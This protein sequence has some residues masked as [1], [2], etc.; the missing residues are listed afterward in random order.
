MIKKHYTVLSNLLAI[1]MLMPISSLAYD[2]DWMILN[3]CSGKNRSC[4][5]QGY[6]QPEIKPDTD[7]G[8]DITLN[9]DSGDML[10]NKMAVLTG[11]AV[12]EQQ[13]RRLVADKIKIFFKD[14]GGELDKLEAF[15]NVRMVSPQERFNGSYAI[16]DVT[17]QE[18]ELHNS[19]YY[20]FS[21]HSFGSSPKIVIDKNDVIHL[22]KA[23]YST[24]SPRD[25][26][27]HLKAKKL[28][29][30]QHSGWGNA[31]HSI[32]YIKDKPVFYWP[33]V[34]FPIDD[35]RKSGLLL[36][37]MQS[38]SYLGSGFGIPYYWNIA[39]N[40]DAT[41]TPTWNTHSG[42]RVFNQFRYLSNTYE[43][44]LEL[45]WFVN[46]RA[47]K[48]FRAEKIAQPGS[49]AVNSV[50]MQRLK[51]LSMRY[52]LN[53]QH[54]GRPNDSLLYQIYYV[55]VGDDNFISNTG[56]RILHRDLSRD[57]H[58]L[59]EI[60]NPQY[61]PQNFLLNYNSSFGATDVELRQYQT[62]YAFNAP[63]PG[64]L[65]RVLPS[66]S[67]TF[68]THNYG[69]FYSTS[70]GSWFNFAQDKISGVS[71]LTTGNRYHVETTLSRP[72]DYDPGWFMSPSVKL[73]ILSEELRRPSSEYNMAKNPSRI[74]P[75]Y[76]LD[77]GLIFERE[78]VVPSN[79]WTQT[80]EPRIKYLYTPHKNQSLLPVFESGVKKFSYGELYQDN[81]FS[82]FDRISSTNQVSVGLSSNFMNSI[83]EELAGI[84]V[85]QIYYL[86]RLRQD[87]LESTM[88]STRHTPFASRA[89]Y[90]INMHWQV[91]AD[92]VY[93]YK[94][95]LNRSIVVG[96]SYIPTEYNIIN[97]NY[98]YSND[99]SGVKTN[100]IGISF[101][102]FPR[103][104]L[105]VQGITHYDIVQRNLNKVGVGLEFYKCCYS[106]KLTWLHERTI[107]NI[108]N[109]GARSRKY[110]NTVG[111]QF[112][113]TGFT[114]VSAKRPID[115]SIPGAVL[116]SD[117]QNN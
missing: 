74:L 18:K 91:D 49:I 22:E 51:P 20:L 108:E 98:D 46:E 26:I 87:P 88:S 72:I 35:R 64:N 69:G 71:P 111:L 45:D 61:L 39:P 116:P 23:T 56:Q 24:C 36:P 93:D 1:A 80:L 34:S 94:K 44:T 84:G 33:Y 77:S 10:M 52:G 67:Q 50:Q 110:N 99:L 109:T 66:L 54:V 60:F 70:K 100:Q 97:I 37:I 59:P 11:G 48:G 17:K 15:G 6:Y 102:L 28:E 95:R 25:R 114:S 106:I 32:L 27:W 5:C 62:L 7:F 3:T 58:T 113:L 30:D 105:L 90:K 73:D 53:L 21:S 19:T 75:T 78:L 42:L 4:L 38:E 104:N 68:L 8:R 31:W 89:F 55:K 101:S 82:G 92:W 43:G 81:R 85:G 13:Q 76:S 117:Y 83:G 14:D 29:M 65:Y 112:S 115:F 2:D 47:Y 16:D 40:Y 57:K 12:A 9:S 96:G 79:E 86:S 103:D 107:H 41:V 63:Q